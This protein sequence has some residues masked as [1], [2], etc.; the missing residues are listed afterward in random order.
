MKTGWHRKGGWKIAMLLTD[1]VIIVRNPEYREA[2]RAELDQ[3]LTE[4]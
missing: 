3:I 4:I 2:A 1:M